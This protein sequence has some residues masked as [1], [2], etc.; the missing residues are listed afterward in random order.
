MKIRVLGTKIWIFNVVKFV[1][2]IDNRV[3][4]VSPSSLSAIDC[5]VSAPSDGATLC[6]KVLRVLG[7]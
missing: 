7:S 2:P 6:V 5:K 1:P 4:F 3:C